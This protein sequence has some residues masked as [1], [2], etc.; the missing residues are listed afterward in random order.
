M[1]GSIRPNITTVAPLRG[2]PAWATFRNMGFSSGRNR[3]RPVRPRTWRRRRTGRNDS[4]LGT[5]G[6]H[7]CGARDYGVFQEE[8]RW[9]PAYFRKGYAER[10]GDRG[11][12][13]RA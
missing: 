2:Q 13:R 8:W 3:I 7:G 9:E 10:H 12:R 5:L 11:A 6:R 1:T 4:V